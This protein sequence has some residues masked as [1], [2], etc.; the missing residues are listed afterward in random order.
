MSAPLM[1]SVAG[2]RGIVGQSLTPPVLARFAAA[3]A[4]ELPA[5][6]VV[7]GR[8]A[9]R[10][11]PMAYRAVAAGLTA[12]G[13]D[14]ADLG[15]ATTPA[16]QVAVETLGAAGGIIL[17]ASHNPAEWN[18]L[19]FLSGR[20]E[21]LD[22]RT[23]AAVRA[24]FESDDNLWVSFDRLGKERSETG[25]DDWHLQ[26]VLA[27]DD[28]D[29]AGIRRRKLK[30]VVDGCASVGGVTAP[31]LLR[32]LGAD[33]VELDC[34]PNGAFT[35][36][37]EPL[38]ENLGAL[39]NAVRD[40]RA[41]F[42]VALDPDADRAALVD[43]DGAP[44]GEEY[45]LAL[46]ARVVLERRRGPAVTNLSTSRMIDAVCERAGVK[47]HRT[48]VGEAHVVAAMRAHGAVFGGEGNGGVIL[49]AAHY[50]RDGLVAVA[51]ICQALSGGKSL[52]SLAG[53]LP[54]LVM[55]KEKA[56]RSA[57]PWEG[58]ANRLRRA[59]P[60][61]DTDEADGLRL[62]RG[63]DWVHVRPSGTEP[64]V[65]LIAESPDEKRTKELLST[66]RHALGEAS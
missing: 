17:T 5:G 43:A 24:R 3:F 64:I 63:E 48:P 59:F 10:S 27:L 35:R 1:I 15:L 40:A 14:V 29:A 42:G 26:R 31:R 13:R 46:T 62:A 45:T 6:E 7:V 53:E 60:G 23:G 2:V 66:A 22:D 33:V 51:L 41:D 30:V 21:F 12:A 57:D 28:L 55:R 56:D 58:V 25:A 65:R 11:G 39:A 37:L 54:R 61:F 4:A 36:V 8:D 52:R 9:R 49:P 38:P 19:K 16:T 20:G 18:A 44:L 50:G 47:L 34:A 32:E